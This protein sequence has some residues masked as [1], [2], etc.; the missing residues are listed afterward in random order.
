MAS[1]PGQQIPELQFLTLDQWV[2]TAK[3][4]NLET[5]DGIRQAFGALR[6][7]AK[8]Q[9]APLLGKALADYS[10]ANGGELPSELQQL[11]Q[12]FQTPVDDSLLQRH[13]L[14]HSGNFAGVAP[15]ETLVAEIAPVDAVYDGRVSVGLNPD[16]SRTWGR[17]HPFRPP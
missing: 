2:A 14:L 7:A 13:Q 8:G 17:Q 12:Y 1:S 9:F 4:A 6:D 5:E 16:G 15:G 11:R 10:A 3:D